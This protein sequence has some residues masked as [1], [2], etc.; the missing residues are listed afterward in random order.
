VNFRNVQAPTAAVM[1][2]PH[3][4]AVNPETLADNAFQAAAGD[5]AGGGRGPVGS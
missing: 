4:F 2:R 3:R 5:D 1:V